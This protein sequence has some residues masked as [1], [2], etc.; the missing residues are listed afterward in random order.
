VELSDYPDQME[1]ELQE[2]GLEDIDRNEL[3]RDEPEAVLSFVLTQVEMES[4]LAIDYDSISDAT[5]KVASDLQEDILT[6]DTKEH[7]A[8]ETKGGSLFNR[9]RDTVS[10]HGSALKVTLNKVKGKIKEGYSTLNGRIEALDFDVERSAEEE[11]A[12][13]GDD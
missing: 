9:H 13:V 7:H 5:R 1:A 11:L 2:L 8:V 3:M 10:R 12:D 6:W 4:A